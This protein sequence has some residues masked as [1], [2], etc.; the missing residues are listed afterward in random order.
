MEDVRY[1]KV[2]V[3]LRHFPRDIP[4]ACAPSTLDDRLQLRYTL[5]Q[6]LTPQSTTP[7]SAKD[8]TNTIDHSHFQAQCITETFCRGED[9]RSNC[10]TEE[11]S[12]KGFLK[13]SGSF[14]VDSRDTTLS[15][16]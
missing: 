13:R 16:Q 12:E 14:L 15:R 2:S 5:I 7:E 4:A 11:S 10:L 8:D 3:T 6:E 1:G 9:R